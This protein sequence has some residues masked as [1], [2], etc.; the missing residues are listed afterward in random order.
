M[1]SRSAHSVSSACGCSKQAPPQNVFWR[2]G[3][4]FWGSEYGNFRKCE[5]FVSFWILW[6]LSI[7]PPPAMFLMGN[8]VM[9]PRDCSGYEKEVFLHDIRAGNGVSFVNHH[10]TLSGHLS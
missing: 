6:P 2:R 5:L 4:V 3:H 10:R 1:S 7:E 9:G 8:S